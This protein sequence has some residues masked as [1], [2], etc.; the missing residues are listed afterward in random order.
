MKPCELRFRKGTI[1]ALHILPLNATSETGK[2]LK[3]SGVGGH[4]Q[5]SDSGK[6]FIASGFAR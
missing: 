2:S 6:R 5:R 1:S 3:L 4:W